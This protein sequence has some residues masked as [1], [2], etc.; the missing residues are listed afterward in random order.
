MRR[1]NLLI[2]AIV[3]ATPHDHI[4]ADKRETLELIEHPWVYVQVDVLDSFARLA[5]EVMV[6]A[7][8][9]VEAEWSHPDG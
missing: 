3:A 4:R 2:L 6:R 7:Y 8:R 5:D 9:G 1:H